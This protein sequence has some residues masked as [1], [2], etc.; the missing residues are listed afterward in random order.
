MEYNSHARYLAVQINER[1]PFRAFGRIESSM[2]MGQ[3]KYGQ[4]LYSKIK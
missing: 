2:G 3:L 4:V 1:Q